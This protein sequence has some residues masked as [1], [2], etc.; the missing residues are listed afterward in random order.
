M[1]L[2]IKI[3]DNILD[4][5]RKSDVSQIWRHETS[6]NCLRTTQK[7]SATEYI[8]F[9]RLKCQRQISSR[10]QQITIFFRLTETLICIPSIPL[11]KDTYNRQVISLF[12]Y[13]HPISMLSVS[14][15]GRYIFFDSNRES[16][17]YLD[18][19]TIRKGIFMYE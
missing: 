1:L 11:V 14:W 17:N 7:W 19:H 15:G 12:T 3:S 2:T 8:N 10:D 16:N 13:H 4:D 6:F 9:D 18:L 5:S